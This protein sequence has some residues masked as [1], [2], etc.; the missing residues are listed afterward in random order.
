MLHNLKCKFLKEFYKKLKYTLTPGLENV[1]FVS[2]LDVNNFIKEART[3]YEAKGT[4]ESFKILFKVLYGETPKVIDLEQY[5]PK[6]SSAKFLRREIVVAE[7]ISG[8]P[9]KLV[10]QTIK[11][12]SDLANTSISF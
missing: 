9:D 3:F 5:L 1:D 2:D 8:D 4:E 7:R 6:P 12:A 11:K 10:G